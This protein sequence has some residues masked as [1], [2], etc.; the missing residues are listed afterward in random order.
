MECLEEGPGASS[1]QRGGSEH[2]ARR[3]LPGVGL[4]R[5]ASGE[6]VGDAPAFTGGRAPGGGSAP[7]AGGAGGADRATGKAK[8]VDAANSAA[9]SNADGFQD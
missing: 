2:P 1:D 8:R 6:L 9:R 5:R 3:R 7:V 4:D